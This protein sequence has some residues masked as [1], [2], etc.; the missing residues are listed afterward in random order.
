MRSGIVTAIL[1]LF[2]FGFLYGKSWAQPPIRPLILYGQVLKEGALVS[3]DTSL[4]LSIGGE[5]IKVPIK[6]SIEGISYYLIKIPSDKI[7]IHLINGT[8]IKFIS[9]DGINLSF[10]PPIHW[11]RGEFVRKD[12]ILETPLKSSPQVISASAIKEEG[13]WTLKCKFDPLKLGSDVNPKDVFYKVKWF[14]AYENEK[15]ELKIVKLKELSVKNAKKILTSSTIIPAEKLNEPLF[16]KLVI[17]PIEK[18][19]NKKLIGPSA[20]F[21]VVPKYTEGTI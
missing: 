5:R 11:R 18:L 15:G 19:P 12:L 13:N 20:I 6:E 2:V 17:Q 4:I 1:V 9:L 3:N 14:Y 7:K 8:E 16:F 21:T 10:L